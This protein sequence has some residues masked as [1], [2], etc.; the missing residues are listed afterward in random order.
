MSELKCYCDLGF[1]DT[2]RV[3]VKSRNEAYKWADDYYLTNEETLNLEPFHKEVFEI[4]Y[5]AGHD[6]QSL[7]IRQLQAE[8]KKLREQRDAAND[9]ILDKIVRN[10]SVEI[11]KIDLKEVLDAEVAAVVGEVK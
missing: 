5:L 8:V 4:A 6:S 11:I 3:H 9:A 7:T 2:C 1:K 10:K